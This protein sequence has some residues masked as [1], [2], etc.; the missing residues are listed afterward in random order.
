VGLAGILGIV[1]GFLLS[2]LSTVGSVKVKESPFGPEPGSRITRGRDFGGASELKKL[3]KADQEKFL[4]GSALAGTHS[5]LPAL[6]IFEGLK[7]QNKD[8]ILAD[9]A[10]AL[11][12]LSFM[13]TSRADSMYA[14]S[15]IQSGL[16]QDPDHPWINYLAGRFWDQARQPDSALAYYRKAI[17]LSPQFAY[18]Y[19]RLGRIEMEKG[20]L[21]QARKNYRTAIGLMESSLDDYTLGKKMVVPLTEV[22]PYDYL[23]TLFYQ[24]GSE[25][26]ALMALEYSQE[27]GWKT[28]QMD[29]VQAWLWE[30]HGFL[31]KADSTYQNLVEKEPNNPVF[32]EAAVTVGWKPASRQGTTRPSDAEAIFAISLLDPLA[33]QHIENAPLWMALGQAYYRRGMYGLAT[34]CFDSS[35]HYDPALPS[36]NEKRDAAYNAMLRENRKPLTAAEAKRRPARPSMAGMEDQ[37]PVIIPGS[38]ALLGTYSVAWGSSQTQVRQAYPK[39]QFQNLPGGNLKDTFVMEG[40][41]H[42]YLLAFKGGKLWGVRAWITDSAGNTGDVFGRMIRTKVKISGE[43]K[44]TGEASCTGF[45]SLQGVIWENDDTFEFMAQFA[46]RETEVR[47]VRID[48]NQLPKNRRLCDLAGFLKDESWVGKP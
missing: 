16:A 2:S 5:S 47:V 39:K 18:P 41:K 9:G 31:A 23:A 13:D 6:E 40:L 43:G 46:G 14:A 11:I 3:S 33:R 27:K 19:I 15:A 1:V 25:D 44:G 24:M 7:K 26:S 21:G 38:I 32:R 42:D 29:L 34:E 22:P 37:T 30:A 28:N 20:D 48:R 45:K 17:L 35:L 36:L 12:Y 10:M 4:R 8:F